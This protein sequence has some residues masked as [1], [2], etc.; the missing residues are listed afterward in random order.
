LFVDK[1]SESPIRDR[2][3]RLSNL[4]IFSLFEICSAIERI[5][6]TVSESISSATKPRT[7]GSS[8]EFSCSFPE[9]SSES[10]GYSISSVIEPSSS[11]NLF[12]ESACESLEVSFDAVGVEGSHGFKRL[13]ELLS[14]VFFDFP[15]SIQFFSKEVMWYIGDA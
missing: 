3:K 1:R 6:F 5:S 8:P 12:F 9:S 11:I 10:S 15:K 13:L 7:F 4:E 2:I 14:A